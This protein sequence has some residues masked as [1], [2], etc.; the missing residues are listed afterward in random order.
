[1]D[2]A[3]PVISKSVTSNNLNQSRVLTKQF[4]IDIESQGGSVRKNQPSMGVKAY[5]L[6]SRK[7]ILENLSEQ[8][9]NEEALVLEAQY[10]N[11]PK[12]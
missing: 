6:K 8:A 12:R 3:T 9:S 11:V 1:M 10:E 4:S 5:S 2:R 7:N